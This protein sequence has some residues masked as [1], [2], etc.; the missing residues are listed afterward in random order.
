M[1]RDVVDAL[2][3]MF[4][5]SVFPFFSRCDVLQRMVE[6]ETRD[7]NPALAGVIQEFESL[8]EVQSFF[9]QKSPI[10]T[11]RFRQAIGVVVA[12][13]M[14]GAGWEK[15]GRKGELCAPSGCSMW[16]KASE[17]YN[18]CTSS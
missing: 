18:N 10:E 2:S 9:A 3:P 12:I 15:T 6:S 1:Y 14:D 7:Q 13:V 11:V 8:P 17:H 5:S 4:Q 16:F